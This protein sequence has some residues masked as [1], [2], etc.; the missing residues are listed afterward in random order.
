MGRTYSSWC[1]PF[2]SLE[3][4]QLL[5]GAA[6]LC[7]CLV[8]SLN[9]YLRDYETKKNSLSLNVEVV[10]EKVVELAAERDNPV[11]RLNHCKAHKETFERKVSVQKLF[12]KVLITA[13]M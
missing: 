4:G 13:L 3:Y 1:N 5:Q 2:I 8:Q 6:V 10:V 9:G 12:V 11:R 7:A